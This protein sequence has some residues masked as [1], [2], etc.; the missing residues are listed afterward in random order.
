VHALEHQNVDESK[1]PYLEF[2]QTI[3]I[4]EGHEVKKCQDMIIAEIINSDVMSFSSDK[5][6]ID[7]LCLL[8][9]KHQPQS[10]E[11][12]AN[13]GLISNQI[14]FHVN[15]IKVGIYFGRAAT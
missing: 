13:E 5:T 3:A 1:V 15:L 12:L 4:I 6:Y 2:L 10:Q 14:A 7:E 11:E 8:M 9:Q